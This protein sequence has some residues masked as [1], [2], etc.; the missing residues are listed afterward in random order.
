[1]S[2]SIA[3]ILMP[4]RILLLRHACTQ[5]AC[6]AL[7]CF[8]AFSSPTAPHRQEPHTKSLARRARRVFIELYTIH[9]WTLPW[10]VSRSTYPEAR[11]PILLDTVVAVK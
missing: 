1:M 3:P 10:D 5:F 9:A 2:D 8:T 7:L 11:A 4:I 6:L